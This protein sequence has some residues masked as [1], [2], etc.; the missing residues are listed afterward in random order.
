MNDVCRG[1]VGDVSVG[2]VSS[3]VVEFA[4]RK[5]LNCQYNARMYTWI[6]TQRMPA[7]YSV[8]FPLNTYVY[9]CKNFS[10]VLLAYM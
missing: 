2:V 4:R 3:E 10:G 7:L 6:Y 1:S 5:T 9:K 8:Q